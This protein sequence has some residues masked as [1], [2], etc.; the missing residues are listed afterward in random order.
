[1]GSDDG[2]AMLTSA[3]EVVALDIVVSGVE[4][5]YGG[6][7]TDWEQ[8]LGKLDAVMLA[9][10]L[11][12]SFHS[13]QEAQAAALEHN[14]ALASG[15]GALLRAVGLAPHT[16]VLLVGLQ[17]LAD[18]IRTEYLNDPTNQVQ[19]ATS[20]ANVTAATAFDNE[21]RL[22]ATGHL[23]A[24][25]R[26][27]A[28]LPPGGHLSPEMDSVLDVAQAE[29]SPTSLANLRRIA[30]SG[31]DPALIDAAGGATLAD[32]LNQFREAFAGH[33]E[34]PVEGDYLSVAE[35]QDRH[36]VEFP[37]GLFVSQ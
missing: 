2:R 29:M 36:L 11:G 21:E 13:A 34:W 14:A 26:A 31:G 33:E 17:P 19:V 16:K 4:T 37:E 8:Q 27:E 22:I 24:A 25:L 3:H 28:A 6:V 10:E 15:Q 30:A 23:V 5:E 18:H 1:M 12:D 7:G 32:D 35:W 20:Q 9:G